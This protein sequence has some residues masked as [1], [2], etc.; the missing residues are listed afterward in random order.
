MGHRARGQACIPGNVLEIV[1]DMQGLL[2]PRQYQRKF[3]Q[4]KNSAFT[5]NNL[6]CNASTPFKHN[7]LFI[8]RSTKC[9]VALEQ[10]DFGLEERFESTAQQRRGD[11]H[12]ASLPADDGSVATASHAESNTGREKQKGKSARKKKKKSIKKGGNRRI[13]SGSLSRRSQLRPK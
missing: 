10:A 3:C 8:L 13:S 7:H 1:Q 2:A 4:N 12:E 9:W 11:E 5:S 6:A